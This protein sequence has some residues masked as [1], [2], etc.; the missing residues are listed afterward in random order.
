L[1][2]EKIIEDRPRSRARVS[3]L[4]WHNRPGQALR[5]WTPRRQPLCARSKSRPAIT[6]ASNRSSRRGST[7]FPCAKPRSARRSFTPTS[8]APDTIT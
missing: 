2:V 6:P 4:P 1:L 3:V 7:R 8:G 5:R